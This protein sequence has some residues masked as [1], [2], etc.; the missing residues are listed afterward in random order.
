MADLYEAGS[1]FKTLNV[2]IALETGSIQPDDVVNDSGA[3][4]VTDHTIRNAE[5]KSH[6]NIN[7]AEVL[8]L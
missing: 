3:I 2:A 8:K 7:I 6:G 1:T 5:L 4:K